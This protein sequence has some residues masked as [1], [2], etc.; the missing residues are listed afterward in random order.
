MWQ[1]Y[2]KV[3]AKKLPK[4]IHILDR[5]HIVSLLNDV[6]NKIRAA[7][8]RE[9][10]REGQGQL[11]KG[12]RY[13]FLKNPENLT[14]KQS[15]RLDDLV[16]TR[17]KSVRAYLWKEKFQLLWNYKSPYWAKVFLE[18]WCKGAMRS[19]LPPL[20]KFVKTIRRHQPLILNW[21][22]A[23]KQFS[24]GIVEG[25]N[26]KVN[27]VTRKSF[28]FRNYETLKVALYHELGRLPEPEVTHRF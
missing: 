13:C 18:K 19:R 3:I 5:F 2:L 25:L 11:L 28:G 27:L 10:S 21:F 16:K 26:R 6:I 1:P 4:A 8:H 12:S 14:T 24:S 9:L 20:K 7:E 17:L 23:K 15:L 22:K